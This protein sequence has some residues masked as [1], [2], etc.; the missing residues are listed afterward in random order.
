MFFYIFFCIESLM[1]VF[2]SN[3]T[4]RYSKSVLVN[5]QW[6]S[7]YWWVAK[8]YFSKFENGKNLISIMVIS[9]IISNVLL[10]FPPNNYLKLLLYFSTVISRVLDLNDCSFCSKHL[11]TL[12]IDSCTR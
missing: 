9:I 4:H 8:M 1:G 3:K 10:I 11:S 7:K 12:K 2:V 6:K 5:V